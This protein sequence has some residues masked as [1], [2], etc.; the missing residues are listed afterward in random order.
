[1]SVM[2]PL[3]HKLPLPS[4]GALDEHWLQHSSSSESLKVVTEAAQFPSPQPPSTAR[5]AG[6]FSSRKVFTVNNGA[7][8]GELLSLMSNR[9][10]TLESQLRAAN[11]ELQSSRETVKKLEEE[12]SFLQALQSQ[13]SDEQTT[14]LRE[15]CEMYESKVAAMQ[16]FLLSYSM[17]WKEEDREVLEAMVSSDD[18][19][20]TVLIKSSL[21]FDPVELAAKI[22][23]LNDVAGDE[24]VV[25]S[26]HDGTHTLVD[27]PALSIVLY[28]DGFTADSNSLREYQTQDAQLFFRDILDGYFPYELKDRFPDGVRMNLIN[29]LDS[30]FEAFRAAA[31]HNSSHTRDVKWLQE[32]GSVG[33]PLSKADFLAK[34]P[35]EVIR[36]GKIVD[37]R[38]AISDIISGPSS[39]QQETWTM[40]A[41][42]VPSTSSSNQTAP[43]PATGTLVPTHV[44]SATAE[45][46]ASAVHIRVCTPDG[47][48]YS[49]RLLGTDTLALLRTYLDKALRTTAYSLH[50]PKVH[51][52]APAQRY[53]ELEKPLA[54]YG[55][56]PNV[57]LYLE[58]KRR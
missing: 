38:H 34:L 58:W 14:A 37:V 30:T 43:L 56:A 32:G 18:G 42:A 48:Q 45:V 40:P 23:E 27:S 41:F 57:K 46:Q 17:I 4:L 35:K 20:G 39:A 52:D 13:P 26:R 36:D 33:M 22:Q 29:R 15:R 53:T 10:A 9:L 11:A 1:M 50:S 51:C 19:Q 5:K 3:R 49:I 16:K 31:V 47:A 55:L 21:P 24:K 6:A 2:A 28:Q 54:D 25:G 44:D 7:K 8:D 12:R